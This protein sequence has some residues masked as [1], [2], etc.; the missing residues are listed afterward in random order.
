MRRL[1]EAGRPIGATEDRLSGRWTCSVTAS[2]RSHPACWPR[3]TASAA[4]VDEVNL[5]HIALDA[6]AMGR[7]RIQRRRRVAQP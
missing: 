1:A 4:H 7:V 2:T 5:L 3:R 6:A